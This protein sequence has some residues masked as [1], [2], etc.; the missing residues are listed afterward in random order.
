MAEHDVSLESI[1]QR[2]SDAGM[3]GTGDTPSVGAVTS[4]VL[5]THTAIERSVRAAIGEIA[6]AADIMVQPPQLIRIE[7]L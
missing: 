4:V 3:P 2:R 7:Q 6:D 5:I 1:V